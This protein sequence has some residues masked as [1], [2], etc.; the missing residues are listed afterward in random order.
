MRY[1]LPTVVFGATLML[2]PHAQAQTIDY[3]ALEE[4]FGEPVT[5]SATGSPQK[6]TETPVTMEIVTADEIRRSGARD[7]PGVLKHVSGVDVL[8]RGTDGYD[9]T[10]RGYD[11]AFS[12]RLL[13]LI[14]GRQVYADFFGYTPWAALPIE[15]NAIRQIEIVKGPNSALFGFNAVG[16]V[17]NIVTYNPLYDDINNLSVTAGTQ[18]TFQSSVVKTIKLGDLGGIRLSAGGNR[19]DEFSTPQ[20]PGDIGTR[21]GNDRGDIDING[22][23]RLGDKTH[24]TI[25]ATH[26]Q[27]YATELS[28]LLSYDYDRYRTDSIKGQVNADTDFGALQGS[29][30]TNWITSQ[31]FT[32]TVTSPTFSFTNE[33]TV[34]QLQDTFK[35]GTDH[36]I[37]V[38]AEYRRNTMET[39]SNGGAQVFYNVISPGAMW[40]WKILPS[41]TLTNALRLDDLM[42]GRTGPVPSD[43]PLANS[44]WN[45]RTIT[46]PSFNSGLVWRADDLDTFRL[47]AARG[48]QMPNLLSLGGLLGSPGGHFFITGLPT[49]EPTIVMN[50]EVS[51]DRTIAAIGGKASINLYHQTNQ[52]LNASNTGIILNNG[53]EPAALNIG[54]SDATGVEFALKGSFLD[55]WRWGLSYAPEFISDHFSDGVTLANTIADFQ[56]TTPTHTVKANLGWSHGPWEIDTYL[57]YKSNFEGIQ[58]SSTGGYYLTPISNYV[59][60]DARVGYK[61][62]DWAT[63]AVSGQN[64]TQ[65]SQHQTS[66]ANVER[67]VFGSFSVNF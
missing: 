24:L 12:P 20:Q 60:V 27:A 63:I 34:A 15:L 37:R 55:D 14:D 50:Y 59:A 46:E 5:T 18:G 66:G 4:L 36:T 22:V 30:Y 56:H 65:A 29:I 21:R 52:T 2:A 57:Q 16:G 41:V 51:W 9:V 8:Q 32:G 31:P 44:D 7:I 42:L 13:V 48:V 3:G 61:L 11:Q 1:Q 25:D 43:F 19:N 10:I 45:N 40:E 53:I 38:S 23:F 54:N 6:V 58:P 64:I 49:L 33:V 35:L 47:S 67:Q 39:T 17:I 28:P 26:S 62:T